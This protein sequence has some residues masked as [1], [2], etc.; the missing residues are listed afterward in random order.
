MLE[1]FDSNGTYNVK[2]AGAK[3]PLYVK[4]TNESDITILGGTRRSIGGISLRKK[5]QKPFQTKEINVSKGD[6]MWLSTDGYIDQN[7]ESRKRFGSPRFADVLD[8]IKDKPL[9]DQYTYLQK[10]LDA[11]KGEAPQR[12]DITVLGIEIRK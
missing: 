11:Y 3:R 5:H 1:K 10:T 2:F 8:I 12:D 4:K 7:D 9:D 6:Y